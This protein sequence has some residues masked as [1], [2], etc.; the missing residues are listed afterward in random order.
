MQSHIG[1]KGVTVKDIPADVFITTLAGHFKKSD[2]IVMPAW[3]DYCKTAC[4]K[5]LAPANP[6]WYFIR[7]ASIAR[8]IYIRDGTGIGSLKEVYGTSVDNGVMPRHFREAS[9]KII[10]T[11]VHQLEKAKLV[12]PVPGRNGGRRVTKQGRGDLDRIASQIAQ[13]AK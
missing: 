10:R 6:D 8:K 13:T 3:G 4:Y 2:H 5:Q 9:G 7:A 1:K 11:I 12:E